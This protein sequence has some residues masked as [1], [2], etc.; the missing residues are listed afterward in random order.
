MSPAR[1]LI[2]SLD[3]LGIGPGLR[4][5]YSKFMHTGSAG[6][7]RHRRPIDTLHESDGRYI[8]NVPNPTS[9][10]PPCDQ[11]YPSSKSSTE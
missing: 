2:L 1:L 11:P 10:P 9:Y 5:S 7:W 4:L 3:C 6:E 8:N